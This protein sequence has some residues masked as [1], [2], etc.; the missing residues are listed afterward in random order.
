MTYYMPKETGKHTYL[1]DFAQNHRIRSYSRDDTPNLRP[2]G[3]L[4]GVI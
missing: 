4:L 1:S 2:I 3:S